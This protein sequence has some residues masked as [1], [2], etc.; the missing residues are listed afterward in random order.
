LADLPPVLIEIVRKGLLE[1]QRLDEAV[2]E[3]DRVASEN[4]QIEAQVYGITYAILDKKEK[5][6]AWLERSAERKE[7]N[8]P[9][10][11]RIPF[12]MRYRDDPVFQKIEKEMGIRR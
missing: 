7:P 1:P 5:A 4:H 6:L 2:A 12:I 10:A 3:L 8:L 11:I 9:Y